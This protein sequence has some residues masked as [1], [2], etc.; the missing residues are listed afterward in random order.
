MP[1]DSQSVQEDGDEAVPNSEQPELTVALMELLIQ[2]ARQIGNSATDRQLQWPVLIR[3]HHPGYITWE[4]Y[5]RNQRMMQANAYGSSCV[6][7][8]GGRGGGA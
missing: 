7:P 2:A 6:E 1:V 3:D 5:E 4:R 8:K